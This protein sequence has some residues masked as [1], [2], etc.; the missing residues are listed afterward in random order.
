VTAKSAATGEP[1]ASYPHMR[2]FI[3]IIFIIIFLGSFVGYFY[4]FSVYQ[5]PK[6]PAKILAKRDPFEPPYKF[7][8]D[9]IIKIKGRVF[10]NTAEPEEDVILIDDGL[11]QQKGLRPLKDVKVVLYMGWSSEDSAPAWH[12]DTI[13]DF[14]GNFDLSTL[15]APGSYDVSLH[16]SKKEYRA[17]RKLFQH[18]KPEHEAIVIM[19]K[20]KVDPSIKQ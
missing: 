8:V 9:S 14:N 5:S 6:I 7:P 13:T 3:I 10:E 17:L 1:Q 15:C 19:S 2:L 11:S 16:V 12:V 4:F 20:K 18:K